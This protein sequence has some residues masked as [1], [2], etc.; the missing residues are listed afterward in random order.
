MANSQNEAL[1]R[2]MLEIM[3]QTQ[4]PTDYAQLFDSGYDNHAPM[5]FVRGPQ[6]FKEL[7]DFWHMPFSDLRLTVEKLFSDG[8]FVAAH[9]RIR[10][11]HTGE[12]FGTQPTGKPIDVSVT[13]I[14]R[15]HSGKV[16]EAWVNPD[17][18]GLMQQIGIV[19]A[20]GMEQRRA[21]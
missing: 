10:G 18:L 1:V 21:A 14:F 6:G 20:P 13:G 11:T 19:Q 9:W 3:N 15:C 5:G 17:R 7:Y 12:F 16:A 8:D 2:R 4:L